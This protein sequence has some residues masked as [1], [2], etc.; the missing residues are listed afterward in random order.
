MISTTP[1]EEVMNRSSRLATSLVS[2][3]GCLLSGLLYHSYVED[4]RLLGA[5]GCEMSWMTPSYI[6]LAWS[7]APSL[8]YRTYLY[9][10]QGWDLDVTVS[11]QPRASLIFSA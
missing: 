8:K 10:E 7:D 4:Q 11:I 3:V 9:R 2:I 6:P 5:W 1:T